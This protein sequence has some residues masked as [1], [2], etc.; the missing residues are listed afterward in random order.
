MLLLR[1]S[2][3]NNLQVTR[4]KISASGALASRAGT[5]LQRNMDRKSSSSLVFSVF[6]CL[7]ILDVSSLSF[8]DDSVVFP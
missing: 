7:S 1:K 8:V 4:K 3:T 5:S 6:A 2:C